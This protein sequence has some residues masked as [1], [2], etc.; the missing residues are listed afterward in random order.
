MNAS[1]GSI[2]QPAVELQIKT[3]S[4]LFR[5]LGVFNFRGLFVNFAFVWD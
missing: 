5:V 3:A 4:E 1:S 2:S